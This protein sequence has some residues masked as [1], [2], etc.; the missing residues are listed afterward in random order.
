M[1]SEKK[2][3]DQRA[4]SAGGTLLFL[5]MS[6]I[7]LFSSSPGS[8]TQYEPPLWYLLER[9][10]AHVFEYA[11]LMLL[12]VRFAR[13]LFPMET[14]RR[15]FLLAGTLSLAYAATDELHQLFVFGR[16]GRMMDV[17]IDGG[18]ILLMGIVLLALR[19][20]GRKKVA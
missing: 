2:T 16:G 10:G 6:M 19:K 12:S 3:S 7:F 14:L 1:P 5:W 11:V 8:G 20:W 4:V 13:A 17:M 9:K 15:I 18:G